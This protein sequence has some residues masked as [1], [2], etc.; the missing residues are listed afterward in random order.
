MQIY[1]PIA[2][3]SVPAE[4]IFLLGCVVGGLSGMFGVGGGF[5]TTPFLIFFGVPPTIAVGTQAN[6]LVAASVSGVMGHWK[7]NNVDVRL[8]LVMLTGGVLGSFIGV[9]IFKLLVFLGQIDFAVSFLYVILLGSIGFMMLIDSVFKML[10][11]VSMRMEFNA[12]KQ[13]DF[14]MMLPYKMRF[15][16]S[17]LYISVLVPGGIG[18]VGGI[19]ASILGIG[20]GFLLVPAMIYFLGVSTLMAAGTSLF[21]IV[22]TTGFSTLMHATFNNTVDIMLALMLILGGVIGSQFGVSIGRRIKPQ[23]ARISLAVIILTVSIFLS[24][25]LFVEPAELFSTVMR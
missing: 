4:T 22:F 18:F 8:G 21:Q 20:G 7:R 23:H 16:K 13:N 1:L 11:P 24:M 10:K 5:L 6:Q 12:F 25:R 15:P 17:K 2:E 9:F 3:I 14:Y 19:L